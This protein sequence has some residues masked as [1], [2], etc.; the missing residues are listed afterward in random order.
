MRIFYYES[1]ANEYTTWKDIPKSIR[2]TIR[3]VPYKTMGIVGNYCYETGAV[4]GAMVNAKMTF[5]NDNI[6]VI[7]SVC[8]FWSF[9]CEDGCLFYD[10]GPKYAISEQNLVMNVIFMCLLILGIL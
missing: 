3:D 6:N 7:H 1:M 5:Q 9:D 8:M 2:D 4:T 10:N